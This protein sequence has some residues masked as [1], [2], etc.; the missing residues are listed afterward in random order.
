MHDFFNH[1]SLQRQLTHEIAIQREENKQFVFRIQQK[2]TD[3]NI[4]AFIQTKSFYLI[5]LKNS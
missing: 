5:L 1:Q 2:A 3:I 4:A